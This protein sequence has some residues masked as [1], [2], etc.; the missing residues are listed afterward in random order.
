MLVM[1]NVDPRA[2]VREL[3]VQQ[4]KEYAQAVDNAARNDLLLYMLEQEFDRRTQ[5][6]VH[7]IKYECESEERLRLPSS[8]SYPD[9][10][11]T[12]TD[13]VTDNPTAKDNN[14][15]NKQESFVSHD[16]NL[17][18][19]HDTTQR[20]IVDDRTTTPTTGL[21][22]QQQNQ[23]QE[24]GMIVS[25]FN[26]IS[27]VLS[28]IIY[29]T[30]CLQYAIDSGVTDYLK[31]LSWIMLCFSLGSNII[32]NFQG[33][34]DT[35]DRIK[36]PRSNDDDDTKS[37]EELCR[38]SLIQSSSGEQQR[39]EQLPRESSN[40]SIQSP[41]RRRIAEVTTPCHRSG[42]GGSGGGDGNTS[43]L[44]PEREARAAVSH[45]QRL[46]EDVESRS[47]QSPRPCHIA[48]VTTPR[49]SGGGGSGG[50]TTPH[51]SSTKQQ[52]RANATKFP[53]VD[54]KKINDAKNKPSS[55]EVARAG[56]VNSAIGNHKRDTTN[57]DTSISSNSNSNIS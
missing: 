49:R 9:T 46:K 27:M 19:R 44:S 57:T 8:S 10:A 23:E 12:G 4:Q 3:K 6:R 15:E 24:Q 20:S 47:T 14:F 13:T 5:H 38:E 29:V 55:L 1:S 37:E 50:G 53:E 31:V 45:T 22:K 51:P 52:A 25:I 21:P 11:T 17:D 41:P 18:H 2:R 56:T 39:V 26:I 32:N 7:E 48:T 30:S 34:K 54:K 42:G 40:Q 36:K 16:D 28:L 43:H 35:K 33:G